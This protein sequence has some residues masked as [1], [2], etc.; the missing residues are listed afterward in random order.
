MRNYGLKILPE[1]KRDFSLG[2]IVSYPSLVGLPD[3]FEFQPFKIKNQ[4]GSDYCTAFSSTSASELQEGVELSP[5]F[6]FAMGQ[7][8]NKSDYGNDLRTA[9]KSHIKIGCIEQKDA[10][11]S[12]DN[13]DNKFLREPNNW[14]EDLLPKALIHAKSSFVDCRGNYDAFDNIRAA[15]WFFKNEKRAVVM[16]VLWEN[17]DVKNPILE[18]GGAGRNGHALACL[19]WKSINNK[20]YLVIQNSYGDQVGDKG[21]FYMSRETVN[22]YVP[23]YGAFTFLDMTPE[24]YKQRLK[25]FSQ[26]WILTALRKI[27]EI[28]GILAKQKYLPPQPTPEPEIP[29]PVEPEPPKYLWDTFENAR[30]SVRVLCDEA[31]LSVA[32]KNLICQ[33]INCESGYKTNAIHKNSN[34]TTDYGIIQANSFWYIGTG[35]PIASIDEALN[36]PEKCV[37][38]MISQ[39]KKG[40]IKDWVCFSSGKY[41]LYG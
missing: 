39:F 21:K 17:W 2:K 24:E 22:K 29:K 34:G 28:L 27:L 13:K 5:E 25:D 15:I 23:I 40:R 12:L 33:I 3:N 32:E 11:F 37:R 30:H 16:G 1:D 20:Q 41:K 36:N 26:N 6:A 4:Q 8:L 35:K 19:G 31:G 7:K 18:N 10:P 14:S 9:M 38:V